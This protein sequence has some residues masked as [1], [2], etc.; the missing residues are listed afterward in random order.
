[1]RRTLVVG[2]LLVVVPPVV[3]WLSQPPDTVGVDPSAVAAPADVRA[4]P[5]SGTHSRSD[6]TSPPARAEVPPPPVEPEHE[7]E[8]P[9]RLVIPAIGVDHPVVEVGRHPD[10]T[11]EIPHDVHEIGWYGPLGIRPG[12]AGAAVL[13]GHVDSRAQ[14][15]GAFFGLRDLDVGDAIV[16]GTEDGEQRWVVSGRNRYPKAELPIETVF[17][18]EGAPRLVLI[19]CG[20]RFDAG[21]RS[22]ADNVVVHA[23]PLEAP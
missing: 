7:G 17:A 11:M 3:W 20:G 16:V 14:G 10:G 18:V 4:F 22:Y 1:M 5:P 6:P 19:T 21:R 23:E 13:A 15:P 2:L 9:L 8:V 12:D